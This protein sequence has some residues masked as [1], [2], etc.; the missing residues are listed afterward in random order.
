MTK[1]LRPSLREKKRYIVFEIDSRHDFTAKQAKDAAIS[2]CLRYIGEFGTA[3]ANPYFINNVYKSNKGIIRVNNKAVEP[4]RA[5]L[6]MVDS[7]DNKKAMIRTLGISGILKKAK[8]K[9]L[10]AA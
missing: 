6:A 9:F 3:K 8:N 4:V 5:C 2:S 7:I 1:P 10:D